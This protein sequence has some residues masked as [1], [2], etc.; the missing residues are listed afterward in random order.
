MSNWFNKMKQID[1][2]PLYTKT[3]KFLKSSS[4]WLFWMLDD[5]KN[6]VNSLVKHCDINPFITNND[7]SHIKSSCT[8]LEEFI[9]SKNFIKWLLILLNDVEIFKKNYYIKLFIKLQKYSSLNKEE[10]E[11]LKIFISNSKVLKCWQKISLNLQE[12]S[13]IKWTNNNHELTNF[14][15]LFNS[16]DIDGINIEDWYKRSN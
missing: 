7:S 4:S 1:F 5:I 14:S 6:K 11:N 2:D 13:I 8:T 16:I 15:E 9:M 12:I 3:K 10:I